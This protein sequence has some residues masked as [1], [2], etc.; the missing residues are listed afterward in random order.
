MPSAE[1]KKALSNLRKCSRL[2]AQIDEAQRKVADLHSD[3]FFF[4]EAV[5]AEALAIHQAEQ[6]SLAKK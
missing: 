3:Q 6:A 5:F 2:D 4:D 1:L